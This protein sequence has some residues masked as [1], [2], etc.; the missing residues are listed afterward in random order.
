MNSSSPFSS[1]ARLSA[2]APLH[3]PAPNWQ[4]DLLFLP[5]GGYTKTYLYHGGQMQLRGG[6]NTEHSLQWCC[7]AEGGGRG[8]LPFWQPMH[9][10]RPINWTLA[11]VRWLWGDQSRSDQGFRNREECQVYRNVW[12][13]AVSDLGLCVLCLVYVDIDYL[14]VPAI[15][16]LFVDVLPNGHYLLSC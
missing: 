10:Y 13:L 6:T 16:C 15:L 8:L 1:R 7:P 3:L 12:V 9:R 11:I 14:C 4:S 2:S 5:R